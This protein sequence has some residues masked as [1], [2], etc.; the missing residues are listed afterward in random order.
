MKIPRD[1]SA[2]DLIKSLERMGYSVDRQKGSH[3]T[4]RCQ[5]DAK[6]HNLTIPNHNP[7]KLG[8]LNNILKDISDFFE[9]SKEELLQK[10]F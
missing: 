2:K 5:R 9:V 6:T 7:I 4:L 3:I 1:V 10:L 8:T